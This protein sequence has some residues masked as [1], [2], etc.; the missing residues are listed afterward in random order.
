MNSTWSQIFQQLEFYMD[1][2]IK[3]DEEYTL[4]QLRRKSFKIP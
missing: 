1:V 2:E 4:L 3:L